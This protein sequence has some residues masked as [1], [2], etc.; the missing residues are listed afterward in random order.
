M[1]AMLVPGLLYFNPRSRERSDMWR[2]ASW[3]RCVHFNPRSREGSDHLSQTALGQYLDFN[4]RSREGSGT[5]PRAW[6][7]ALKFQSTLP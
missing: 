4:P 3:G 6:A 7:W 5:R 1:G 2:L